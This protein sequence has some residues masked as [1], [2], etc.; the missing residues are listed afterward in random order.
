MYCIVDV[1]YGSPITQEII[2]ELAK[3]ALEPADVGYEMLYSGGGDTPPGYVGECLDTFDE[4]TDMALPVS[5]L[6]MRPD[7]AQITRANRKF[8]ELPREIRKMAK[9]LDV[10]F[11]FY[12]S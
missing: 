3:L 7:T 10:Y 8:K 9:P 5:S 1:I 2:D 12:T 6:M 4:A 11:V